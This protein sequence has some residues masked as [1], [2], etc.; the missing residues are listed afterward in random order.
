LRHELKNPQKRGEKAA[1]YGELG[2][3]GGKKGGGETLGRGENP[4]SQEKKKQGNTTK[5]LG[6]VLPDSPLSGRL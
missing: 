6:L 3:E 5:G 1:N 4:V 2:G